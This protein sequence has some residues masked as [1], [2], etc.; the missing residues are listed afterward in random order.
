MHAES[1]GVADTEVVVVELDDMTPLRVATTVAVTEPVGEG[2]KV[3]LNDIIGV[4]V[5]VTDPVPE[6]V[7]D[8]EAVGKVVAL[9]HAVDVEDED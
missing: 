5:P 8:V 1:D 2:L 9:T 4:A 7:V 3:P 6:L